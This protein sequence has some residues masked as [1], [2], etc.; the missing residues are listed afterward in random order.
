MNADKVQ[1]ISGNPEKYKPRP[2]MDVE[3][4]WVD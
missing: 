4:K 3:P 2:E 1:M